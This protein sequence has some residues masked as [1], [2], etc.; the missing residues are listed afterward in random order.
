MFLSF[1]KDKNGNS[2]RTDKV[3]SHHGFGHLGSERSV[4]IISLHLSTTELKSEENSGAKH[5]N[6]CFLPPM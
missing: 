6:C 2:I 1:A 5:K 3:F 4:R